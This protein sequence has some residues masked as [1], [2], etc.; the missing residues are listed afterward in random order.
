LPHGAHVLVSAIPDP[1]LCLA[2]RDDLVLRQFVPDRLG[3]S[4]AGYAQILA[5]QDYLIV[6]RTSPSYPVTEFALA[7]GD[8]AARVVVDLAHDYAAVV[9]RVRR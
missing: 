3:M 4:P 6:G 7:H 1:T 9:V 8:E 5:A 2:E